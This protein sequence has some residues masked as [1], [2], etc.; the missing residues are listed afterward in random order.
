MTRLTNLILLLVI[1]MVCYWF[2]K[3][4]ETHGDAEKIKAAVVAIPDKAIAAA[5]KISNTIEDGT[6]PKKAENT[7]EQ[8][9]EKAIETKEKIKRDFEE[10][11][12]KERAQQD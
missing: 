4:P 1:I 6:I 11:K 9:K 3:Q 8:T 5:A 7:W 2:W 12:K 10:A